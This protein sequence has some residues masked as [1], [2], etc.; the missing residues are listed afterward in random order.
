ME[1]MVG[2]RVRAVVGAAFLG[3]LSSSALVGAGG[4][5]GAA[6]SVAHHPLGHCTKKTNIEGGQECRS[7]S[8]DPKRTSGISSRT[9]KVTPTGRGT[10]AVATYNTDPA[11]LLS[12]STGKYFGVS[13]GASNAFTSLTLKDCSLGGGTTLYWWSGGEWIPVALEPGSIASASL[14]CVSD[15]LGPESSPSLAQM[16]KLSRASRFGAVVFGVR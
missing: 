12:A 10:V 8:L 14:T 6:T 3:A 9:V 2:R 11:P 4:A 5:A 1:A 7:K 15:T 13:L 16:T